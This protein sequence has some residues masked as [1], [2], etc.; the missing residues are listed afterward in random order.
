MCEHLGLL[1]HLC[2]QL[3]QKRLQLLAL[4][5]LLDGLAQVENLH[6]ELAVLIALRLVEVD[7]EALLQHVLGPADRGSQDLVGLV[8]G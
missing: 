2:P 3:Q 5:A 1:L 8:R 6:H 7:A 4:L